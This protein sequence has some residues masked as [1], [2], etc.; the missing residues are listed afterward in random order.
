MCSDL[1]LFG[2]QL[3]SSLLLGLQHRT[4]FIL[5]GAIEVFWALT[6]VVPLVVVYRIRPS[7]AGWG[8]A[9]ALVV[10][11]FFTLLQAVIEGARSSRLG[12][13]CRGLGVLSR[14]VWLRAI[15]RYTSASS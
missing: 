14:R 7:I 10:V 3:K 4:D 8:F 6:A 9:D 2:V 13:R 1:R 15:A 11:G 5:D 12:H